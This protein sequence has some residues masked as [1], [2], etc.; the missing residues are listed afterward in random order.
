MTE[1]VKRIQSKRF[2]VRCLQVLA[3]AGMLFLSACG[4]KFFPDEDGGGGGG[5]GGTNSGN[6]IY[7]GNSSGS[8]SFNMGG[9]SIANNKLNTLSG[10]PF[11]LGTV[12]PSSL[13]ITPK[14]T[15]LYIGSEAGGIYV[16]TI[17]NDGSISIGNSGQPV[18]TGILPS[19]IKV[20]T[21]GNW[22]IAL[23]DTGGSNALAYVFSINTSNGMLTTQNS[24]AGVTLDVG[25]PTHMV[26]SPND[27]QVYVT[28]STGGVD[29]LLFNSSSGQL[30][31]SQHLNTKASSNADLGVAIDPTGTYLFVTETGNVLNNKNGLRVLKVSSNAA[32]NELSTSPVLTGMGPSSVLVSSNGSYVYV[33]NRTDGTVSGFSLATTGALT[34]LTGSP[35]S[36]GQTPL[37]LVEDNT[38]SYIAVVCSNGN[39]DLQV[40]KID[41]TTPGQL[42]PFGTAATGTDPTL[43]NS[44][45][46]TN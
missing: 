24:S 31:P 13:A 10:S 43:P 29:G 14:N 18:A 27:Q 40:F 32:M 41:T 16:Y 26:F 11:N 20:D 36:T 42:D 3:M 33:T 6:Y 2:G 7:V 1:L 19:V 37:D 30:T 35:Y 9:F 22:L 45:V 15:F 46:T 12:F 5:G 25:S 28:L 4:G 21:T 8:G 44:I 39:P 23:Q 17:N 34:A 38:H